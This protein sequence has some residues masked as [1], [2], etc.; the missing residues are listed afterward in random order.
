M[1]YDMTLK[2]R[3]STCQHSEANIQSMLTNLSD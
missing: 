1:L 2:S 3:S